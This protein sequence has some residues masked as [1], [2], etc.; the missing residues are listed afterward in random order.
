M[1]RYNSETNFISMH[2]VHHHCWLPSNISVV[3]SYSAHKAVHDM[4]MQMYA[5]NNGVAIDRT[6]Q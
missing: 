6:S 3:I 4:C 2:M 1:S 5:Y